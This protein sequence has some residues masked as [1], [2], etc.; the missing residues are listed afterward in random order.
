MEKGN[1][2]SIRSRIV[3][4]ALDEMRKYVTPKRRDDLYKLLSKYFD[5]NNNNE[6]NIF[7]EKCYYLNYDKLLFAEICNFFSDENYEFNYDIKPILRKKE[8]NAISTALDT[9]I[10]I[11]FHCKCSISNLS[12]LKFDLAMEL[13]ND[14]NIATLEFIKWYDDLFVNLKERVKEEISKKNYMDSDIIK[15]IKIQ[16]NEVDHELFTK[17]ILYIRSLL[18]DNLNYSLSND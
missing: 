17:I 8:L 3:E 12:T 9:M 2:N 7:Q 10:I 16:S 4:E 14:Y 1:W 11:I 18:A 6:S 13:S 5:I 15:N